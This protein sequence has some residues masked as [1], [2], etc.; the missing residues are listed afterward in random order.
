M[1]RP[2]LPTRSFFSGGRRPPAPLA[3]SLA[4]A[5]WPH[6]APAGAPA[7]ALCDVVDRERARILLRVLAVERAVEQRHLLVVL[8]RGTLS[9]GPSCAVARGGPMAPLRSGG[10]LPARYATLWTVNERAYLSGSLPSK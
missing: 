10:R 2:G 6:S 1:W 7:G 4:G 8:F 5:P 3:P 9:P